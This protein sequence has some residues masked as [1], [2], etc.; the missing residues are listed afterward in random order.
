MIPNMEHLTSYDI[1]YLINRHKPRIA[2]YNRNETVL[3]QGQDSKYIEVVLEGMVYLCTEDEKFDRGIL[4]FFRKGDCFS[5]SMLIPSE[6]AVSYFYAKKPSEIAFF[7]RDSLIRQCHADPYWTNKLTACISSRTGLRSSM[8]IF[9][10][11]QKS[12]RAKLMAFFQYETDI[13]NKNSITLPLPLT[14]L[15]DYICADR[16]AMMKELSVMKKDGLISGK[17]KNITVN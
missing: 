7:S 16:S 5:S 14:D 9:I 4:G 11:Q 2:K 1:N 6:Y 17:G 10:L 15:A 8:H 3:H 12:I 13:H